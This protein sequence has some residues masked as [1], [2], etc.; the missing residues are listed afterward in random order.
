LH[1]LNV[2]ALNVSVCPAGMMM[3]VAKVPPC[4]A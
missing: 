2:G 4:A 1:A 3:P